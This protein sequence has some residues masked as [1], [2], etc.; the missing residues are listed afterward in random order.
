MC[1]YNIEIDEE[2]VSR[3][4]PSFKD[5]SA[6]KEWMQ[7]QI[8]R[9]MKQYVVPALSVVTVVYVAKKYGLSEP[10]V[11]ST[12]KTLLSF[13]NVV[14]L[15]SGNVIDMLDSDWSD[16]EDSTQNESAKQIDADIIATGNV[17]DFI[18][19][20]IKVMTPKQILEI[21]WRY[22]KIVSTYDTSTAFK[23]VIKHHS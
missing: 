12:L 2:V 18:G 20:D 11:K 1:V 7:E 13:I 21:L 6:L 15:T 5:D 17:K 10:A 22:Y 16:Y 23:M 8:V 19:S 14:D 9:L 4:R 3:V